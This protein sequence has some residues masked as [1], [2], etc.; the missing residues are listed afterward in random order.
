MYCS[1]KN[2]SGF[3]EIVGPIAHDYL[4]I[5][6]IKT[7]PLSISFAPRSTAPS[8][9]GNRIDEGSENTCIYKN[10]KYSLV[11]VQIGTSIHKGFNLPGKKD[12]PVAELFLSFSGKTDVSGIIMSVP[13][14]NSGELKANEY[15]DQLIDTS[16]ASCNY[17]TVASSEYTGENYKENSGT[18]LTQCVKACCNDTNCVAYTFNSGKC[19]LKKE[20]QP[21]NKI[22]DSSVISGT[23]NH[24]ALKC[25]GIT[26]VTKVYTLESIFKDQ[27]SFAYK[28]CFETYTNT[29]NLFVLVFPNGIHMTPANYQQLILQLNGPLKS[30][31]IPS[32]IRNDTRTLQSYT[33]EN[34]RKVPTKFSEEGII[35]TTSISSCSDD[36]KNK[37]EYF[38]L[39][40]RT[41]SKESFVTVSK[42]YRQDARSEGNIE[43]F[44]NPTEGFVNPI[45]YKCQI[46]KIKNLGVS[47]RNYKCMP[48]DYKNVNGNVNAYIVPNTK[49]MSVSDILSKASA[50]SSNEDIENTLT[51]DQ[52]IVFMSVGIGGGV[53]FIGLVA[54]L[55][56]NANKK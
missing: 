47:E 11:D 8:L 34:A 52:K 31:T 35:Y 46:K 21:I 38:T 9:L 56:Y 50:I 3:I 30:Y 22:S 40:P 19:N 25:N 10:T 20:I 33:L 4:N 15:L 37:F 27:P 48:F 45:S 29:N 14:Y 18:S 6:T 1:T 49:N 32:I 39:S 28:T 43:G 26:S 17:T 16:M 12:Q 51:T 23:V 2:N 55:I 5:I 13:I 42:E 54:M 24:D 44:V 7:H 36:F 41:F 53:I